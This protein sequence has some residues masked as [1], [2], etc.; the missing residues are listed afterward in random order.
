M[1]TLRPSRFM[2]ATNS[3]GRISRRLLR[4][5]NRPRKT[6]TIRKLTVADHPC[7]K[8]TRVDC[9]SCAAPEAADADPID[10]RRPSRGTALMYVAV[11]RPQS[12]LITYHHRCLPG[13]P[14]APSVP[15]AKFRGMSWVLFRTS[16][17]GSTTRAELGTAG[18][19]SMLKIEN[20]HMVLSV[21]TS[22]RLFSP[23]DHRVLG[24]ERGRRRDRDNRSRWPQQ[25]RSGAK[26]E[27]GALDRFPRK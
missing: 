23:P 11:T 17:H 22:I 5:K 3:H 13:S 14:P 2:K 15:A 10:R 18:N 19:D 9:S 1:A 21:L 4:W 16:R 6:T 7:S 26:A 12:A 8:R 20:P 25:N 24:T 27:T